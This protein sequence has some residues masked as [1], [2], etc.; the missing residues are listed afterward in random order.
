[1]AMGFDEPTSQLQDHR[2]AMEDGYYSSS[3]RPSALS[4]SSEEGTGQAQGGYKIRSATAPG[5][6]TEDR[7]AVLGHPSMSTTSTLVRWMDY[8]DLP[9]QPQE[10][11]SGRPGYQY[12]YPTESL[13][14]VY[15]ASAAETDSYVYHARGAYAGLE[16]V[17]SCPRIYANDV[18]MCSVSDREAGMGSY[19]PHYYLVDPRNQQLTSPL[20]ASSN[21][22]TETVANGGLC[23]FGSL[24][25]EA[26]K[27][28]Q[29]ERH[30]GLLSTPSATTTSPTDHSHL[31]VKQE[32]SDQYLSPSLSERTRDDES[33]VGE[34]EPYAK[35]I[36][37]ALLSAPG[38]RMVLKDIYD[39]FIAHTDKSKNPSQKGWQNSIRHN[40][41]MNG[42]FRKVE[43]SSPDD[44]KKG[45]VWLL[46]PSALTHGVKSTTRY[47][48][49]G[50]SKRLARSEAQP[51]QPRSSLGKKGGRR[52]K[53]TKA[54]RSNKAVA[55]AL[56]GTTSPPSVAGAPSPFSPSPDHFMDE[57]AYD[58][59][60]C[61]SADTGVLPLTPEQIP[62]DLPEYASHMYAAPPLPQ[63]L[64]LEHAN[65]L[66]EVAG[67]TDD[68]GAGPFFY[69][70]SGM[71]ADPQAPSSISL[72]DARL[73]A[74]QPL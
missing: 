34:N 5:N 10:V 42:A 66:A 61:L 62:P 48:K 19:P 55:A 15:G 3:W 56:D 16:G 47:R 13:A 12:L 41:S 67:I 73:A 28:A 37:K 63:P 26:R 11:E 45:F 20:R 68:F 52:G 36:Y 24:Q 32:C 29:D 69:E 50:T 23:A 18:G 21:S 59:G 7:S 25:I 2:W 6:V 8:P 38:H 58:G 53:H 65:G 51:G 44:A 35:L 70:G 31:L 39:W 33:D 14:Q 43:Q 30:D 74:L 54:K 46:E 72:C 64:K 17:S 9:H 57:P 60:A 49:T 40:L 27:S 71:D 4:P 22:D 1:M